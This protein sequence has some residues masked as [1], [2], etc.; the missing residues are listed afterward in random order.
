MHVNI[1]FITFV[2]FHDIVVYTQRLMVIQISIGECFT[3]CTDCTRYKQEKGRTV[4]SQILSHLPF[5]S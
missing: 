5:P 2:R 3:K 1:F 4:E